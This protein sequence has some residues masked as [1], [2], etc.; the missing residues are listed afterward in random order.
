MSQKITILGST[1]SIGKQSLEVMGCHPG[2][3]TAEVLTACDNWQLLA[4]QARR[5]RPNAVVIAN[6]KHYAD[7]RD[8]LAGEDIKVYAGEDALAQSVS[9]GETDTVISALVG[10]AGLRPTVE[11]I[12]AGKKIALANKETMVVAGELV[13]ALSQE[14]RAPIL[15]VD[16]EH[17][18]ILQC[19][20]GEVTPPKRV[21]I[22]AS[23]GALRDLSPE[24]M[25]T[26]T[27]EQALR[28]PSWDMGP[29]ITIDSATMMNKGFEVIEA[30]W[31]FGLPADRIDVVMH[32]QSIVHS[33]VEFAD[34]S[35]KAQMGLPDMKLPIQY[36]LTWPERLP[37]PAAQQYE[38]SQW[39]LTFS[40]PD[41]AKYP[42]LPM[43]YRAMEQGGNM[44]CA[45]NAA[46]EIAVAAFLEGKIA[47]T[48]IYRVVEA[49]LAA[50]TLHKPASLEEIYEADRHARETARKMI[51]KYLR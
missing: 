21:I 51:T 23:G 48:D 30:K 27:P 40:E 45:L 7:L 3:F 14:H 28:H 1:G 16:S 43:A 19:L 9:G 31:F 26:V 22:T 18:A 4:E 37:L 11:A 33:F 46:N 13:T 35:V 32:P 6:E 44:S 42:C 17:S 38:P 36:A 24:E 10:F 12:R 5:F 49:T 2:H 20:A 29:K 47:F 50:T 15:P 8:A 25:E 34:G 39:N 41:E